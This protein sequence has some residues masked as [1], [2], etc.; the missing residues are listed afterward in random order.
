MG[1]HTDQKSSNTGS[2]DGISGTAHISM[3]ETVKG[4]SFPHR[5]IFEPFNNSKF[6]GVMH[7]LHHEP[8]YRFLVFTVDTRCFDEFLLKA[9]NGV[10]L[11][12][13]VE[14]NACCVNHAE[15]FKPRW[16]SKLWLGNLAQ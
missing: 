11:V 1:G 4:V 15:L 2:Q 14:V 9:W 7:V 8:I 5:F 16:S 10:R 13:A 12:I 6:P 3:L